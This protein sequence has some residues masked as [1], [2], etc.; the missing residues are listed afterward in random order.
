MSLPATRLFAAAL[1]LL[2]GTAHAQAPA[3]KTTTTVEKKA[4][5]GPKLPPLPADKSIPQSARIGGRAISYRATVGTIPVRD[6]KGKEI[7][8]VT[9]TAYTVPGGD[10]ARPVTFAFNGGPGAASVYLNL[11]AVGPKRIQF[12]AQ[13]RCA[14]GRADRSRQPQQLARF[15]R[16]R[17]HRSG[18]HGVQPKP[19]R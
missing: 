5:E 2:G 7:G 10:P 4:E 15:H 3:D 12:G 11:G 17:L 19:G 14:V 13:G 9:Y 1:L 16:S 18:R 6:D 8:Q